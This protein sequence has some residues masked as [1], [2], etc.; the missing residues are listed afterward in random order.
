MKL[1]KRN[2]KSNKAITLIA[3]VITIIVLL[4]LAGVTIATL[5]GDNGLLTKASTAKNK[6][7][8]ASEMEKIQ[9]E[10]AGAYDLNGK[11]DVNQLY[12]HIR[13]NIKDVKKIKAT[14]KEG[15]TE[16]ILPIKV[17]YSNGNKYII[18]ENGKVEEYNP[19]LPDEYQQVDSIEC[20]GNQ[21]INISMENDNIF[22]NIGTKFKVKI[23]D[24]ISPWGPVIVS[25]N[26]TRLLRTFL[27]I[28]T[29]TATKNMYFDVNKKQTF[30]DLSYYSDP[31][32]TGVGV[33]TTVDLNSKGDRKIY[34]NDKYTTTLEKE[35][36]TVNKATLFCIF[37]NCEEM[38][39][40]KF[41]GYMY[42]SLSIYNDGIKKIELYPCYRIED[43]KVGLYD[44][45]NKKFYTNQG[46][47]DFIKGNNV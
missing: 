2:L 19:I 18:T 40:S 7:E 33:T 11:L 37:A 35:D 14:D 30:V 39:V 9:V 6:T 46:T 26:P 24:R 13:D 8:K 38:E 43:N 27:R 23:K 36:E 44:T 1:N 31:N 5:T 32:K 41:I 10:V 45:I 16:K 21:Y 29:D 42:D 17:T 22:N 4:I 15:T 3:L 34:I 25:T 47:G 20:D 28:G 12:N